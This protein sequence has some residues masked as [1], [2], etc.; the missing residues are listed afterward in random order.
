MRARFS[1]PARR[2]EDGDTLSSRSFWHCRERVYV[3]LELDRHRAGDEPQRVQVQLYARLYR[4]E[5][6][7]A[8]EPLPGG[9]V[10]ALVTMVRW[11]PFRVQARL[12][13]AAGAELTS[14][15]GSVV[16]IPRSSRWLAV[17]L[18]LAC[19]LLLV[20]AVWMIN[21]ISWTSP[22]Q[23]LFAG[24]A[25]V[26]A[27]AAPIY[28]SALKLTGLLHHQALNDWR[29]PGG[30]A[31][32]L[33]LTAALVRDSVIWVANTT[34]RS[35]EL[36]HRDLPAHTNQ[37]FWRSPGAF[38]AP[39]T[40]LIESADFEIVST[41]VA[42][43]ST[44]RPCSAASPSA[45]S[46]MYAFAA[47]RRWLLGCPS[48][49]NDQCCTP[50]QG[51]RSFGPARVRWELRSTSCEVALPG[52]QESVG[53]VA[54]ALDGGARAHELEMR[55][56]DAFERYS[57]SC[58]EPAPGGRCSVP[59]PSP[60]TSAMMSLHLRHAGRDV[61]TLDCRVGQATRVEALTVH[62]PGLARVV[63]RSGSGEV[64]SDWRAATPEYGDPPLYCVNADESV[65]PSTT[66]DELRLCLT[67]HGVDLSRWALEIEAGGSLSR[68]PPSFILQE[69][70]HPLGTV[71][72]SGAALSQG[73]VVTD[74]ALSEAADRLV[75]VSDANGERSWQSTWQSTAG[76]LTQGWGCFPHGW[77][78]SA[79]RV[80]QP[81]G[82][83]IRAS[84]VAD[85][86]ELKHPI[87][88][89]FKPRPAANACTRSLGGSW[90][91][92]ACRNRPGQISC[93]TI[94]NWADK[95]DALNCDE[96]TSWQCSSPVSE[97]CG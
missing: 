3:D 6:T 8:A 64:Q 97:D 67:G 76:G 34:G 1:W 39:P 85:T 88:T 70:D 41:A 95:P 16:I 25:T 68:R 40:C 33:L 57:V 38:S 82:H 4:R 36:D 22:T 55:Q 93:V 44:S 89:I 75:S 11:L 65:A 74:F 91:L 2:D 51:E 32:A 47:S 69:D 52:G 62:Q 80:Q 90:Q 5:L 61:G 49:S 86:A 81:R 29:I 50:R 30:A 71:T 27:L 20:W 9:G 72:C 92:G 83:E 84:I 87:A 96:R 43:A 23:R 94:K 73:F 58:A 17:T 21:S 53:F 59:I 48:G 42:A 56:I 10:T 19:A 13:D 77:T 15:R 63:Y 37:L 35:V 60:V 18:S 54:L 46:P 14:V 66:A 24:T 79:S 31:L 7:W 26:I 45:A 28:V 12:L 78:A